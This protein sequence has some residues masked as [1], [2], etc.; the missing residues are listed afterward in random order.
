MGRIC[1]IFGLVFIEALSSC[2]FPGVRRPEV[3][4]VWRIVEQ[5]KVVQF[6]PKAEDNYI[7]DPQ[8]QEKIRM[9]RKGRSFVLDVDMVQRNE[10][11]V[12]FMRQA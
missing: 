1:L 3:A 8:M 4:A 5:G 2:V 12:P 10:G 11:R 6:G 9:R 7:W